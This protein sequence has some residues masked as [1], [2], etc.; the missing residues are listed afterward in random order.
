[1]F[2]VKL[3]HREISDTTCGMQVLGVIVQR[4]KAQND[5][6]ELCNNRNWQEPLIK[7]AASVERLRQSNDRRGG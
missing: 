3:T 4:H 5:R 1:M 6:Q 7:L 2:Q